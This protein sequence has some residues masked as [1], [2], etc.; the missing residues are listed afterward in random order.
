MVL[1]A[2]EVPLESCD[3]FNDVVPPVLTAHSEAVDS[4]YAS[5]IRLSRRL[6]GL[7]A[8][9]DEEAAITR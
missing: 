3:W 2:W 5:C 7:I 9:V 8:S 4:G 1:L 6:L